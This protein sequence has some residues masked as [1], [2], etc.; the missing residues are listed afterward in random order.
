VFAVEPKGK[1]LQE[2][3]ERLWGGCMLLMLYSILV[4]PFSIV[5]HNLMLLLQLC[6]PGGLRVLD[7]A[8]NQVDT[9]ADGTRTV[10][11]GLLR[12]HPNMMCSAKMH[13]II[14]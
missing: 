9:I 8:L 5:V 14:V 1:R 2:A 6:P 10:P 11:L 4:P 13:T 12:T 7:P 3:F